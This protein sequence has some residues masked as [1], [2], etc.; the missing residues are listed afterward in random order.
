MFKNSHTP[1]SDLRIAPTVA[2]AIV[3]MWPQET[4]EWGQAFASELPA[5]NSEGATFHWLIGGIMLLLR[6]WLRHA[7]RS[8][9]RPIGSGETT[10]SLTPRYSR[11][12]RTPLWLMLAL[13]ASSIAILLHPELRQAVRKLRFDYA[14]SGSKPEQWSS[15]KQLREISKS[16]RDPHLLALLSLLSDDTDQ[17]LALSD[18]AIRKDPSLTWVDFEQSFLPTHDFAAQADLSNE[19]LDRLQKWDPNNAVP[20]LLAAEV[21]AKPARLEAF[22]T[23]MS[24]NRKTDWAKSLI[25]NPRWASEMH[26]AFSAPNY[27]AYV[28]QLI[29]LVR[30]VSSRFAVQDPEIAFY[31]LSMRRG[32]RFDMS[33]GYAGA[34]MDRAAMLEASGKTSEAI[35]TFTELLH[36]A[37]RMSL[38]GKSLSEQYFGQEIGGDAGKKLAPIY[39][40]IGRNAEASFIRFQL[41]KWNA[42]HDPRILRYVPLYYRWSQWSSLAWSGL[43]ISAAGFAI[44]LAVPVTL[45]ALLVAVRR[46]KTPLEQR[47]AADFWAS[48]CADSAP[49]LLFASSVLLYITYH[50]Y[51]RVCAAFLKGGDSSPSIEAFLTASMVPGIVPD[52][53]QFVY[54]PYSWWFALTT[55]LS[56]LLVFF[57]WRMILRRSKAAV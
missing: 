18:E 46:R 7:W 10:G 9:G 24:G 43:I 44:S 36:F 23:L 51:A 50:P 41:E 31:V 27:D 55:S 14:D 16:N 53:V 12:P 21:I 13:T 48:L 47:G 4:R 40:S 15:V 56:A 33:R 35:G 34:L 22:D 8:L 17:R 19:K 49:W 2:R 32:I 3:R 26:A 38:D 28:P 54:D 37:E 20:H 1:N 5:A 11:T 6:E 29:E 30:D 45:I 42:E 52:Y 57:L 39:D 25:D